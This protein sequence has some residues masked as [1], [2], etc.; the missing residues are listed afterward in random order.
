MRSFRFSVAALVILSFSALSAC[1]FTPLYGANAV[2]SGLS[3]IRVETGQERIDFRLQEALLD[4]MSAR[5]AAGPYT[6]HATTTVLSQPFGVGVDAIASRFA[7]QVSVQW[8]LVR[9]GSLEPIL[10]GIA[11]SDAS[12]D[13]PAGVY[14][15]LAAESDAENRAIGVAADRIITQLARSIRDEDA[16]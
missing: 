15:G 16:W 9:E 6:L 11:N 4:G 3:D 1:G 13:V 8:Q 7:V 14:G 5:H 12:Y 2:T 10:T